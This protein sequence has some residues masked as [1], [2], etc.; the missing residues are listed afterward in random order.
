MWIVGGLSHFTRL[1]EFSE[2]FRL[3]KRLQNHLKGISHETFLA[4]L[5]KKL[6]LNFV[7]FADFIFDLFLK[8]AVLFFLVCYNKE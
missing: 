8:I 2:E 5:T 3:S 6:I 1:K 7:S 4:S